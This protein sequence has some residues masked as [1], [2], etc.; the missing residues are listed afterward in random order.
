MEP[1]I[2]KPEVFNDKRGNL[3]EIF[4]MGKS[5]WGDM[6]YAQQYIS[7][8]HRNVWRGLHYQYENPQGKLVTVLSGA[9]Y[10]YIVDLRLRSGTFGK[11]KKFHLTAKSG[12]MLWVPPCF[13]HGFLSLENDTQMMYNVFDSVRV[14]EDEHSIYPLDFP[15]IKFDMD[16]VSGKIIMSN[17]DLN[18]V[19][20]KDAPVYE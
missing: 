9:V 6:Y 13:A 4:N 20:F 2:I 10:D 7:T 12:D 11:I 3:R 16:C 14:P 18:G 19:H 8:S 15:E 5:P 1:V 17:K